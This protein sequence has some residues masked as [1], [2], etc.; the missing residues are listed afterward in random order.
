MRY[1]EL[2]DANAKELA[3]LITEEHGKT[4]VDAVGEVS[5][6]SRSSS[7]RWAFRIS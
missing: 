4:L 5:A 1:R 2:I 3:Q 6:A 7:S